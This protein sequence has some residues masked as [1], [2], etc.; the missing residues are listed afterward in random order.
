[1]SKPSSR[2]PTKPQP[3]LPNASTSICSSATSPMLSLT[4]IID[5]HANYGVPPLPSNFA[6]PASSGPNTPAQRGPEAYPTLLTPRYFTISLLSR[7]KP[8]HA[9]PHHL[10]LRHVQ[11]HHHQRLHVRKVVNSPSL[12]MFTMRLPTLL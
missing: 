3:E 1:M 7:S 5:R 11:V 12:H 8:N 6:T 4:G 2:A 10:M 9:V